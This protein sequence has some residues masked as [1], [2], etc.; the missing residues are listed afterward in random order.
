MKSGGINN[1]AV[2][3][4]NAT[5][6]PI[7]RSLINAPHYVQR[8]QSS[9]VTRWLRSH[10]LIAALLALNLLVGFGWAVYGVNLWLLNR[11]ERRAQ[12]EQMVK[13]YRKMGDFSF[14]EARRVRELSSR[15]DRERRLSAD[16][17]RLILQLISPKVETTN[18]YV[19]NSMLVHTLE[20]LTT[21][22]DSVRPVTVATMRSLI[23]ATP[24]R[25][26]DTGGRSALMVAF[27]FADASER[28]GLMIE[29]GAATGLRR[30]SYDDA[31][32]QFRK[33]FPAPRRRP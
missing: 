13:I 16:E 27:K 19:R 10:R 15:S 25:F 8:F 4:S 7:R 17:I 2:H 20:K 14:S 1:P 29:R 32:E 5:F 6:G 31:F 24:V 23:S 12:T 3:A 26:D 33:G 28:E 21:V 30:R 9:R 18:Q 11:N 22:P